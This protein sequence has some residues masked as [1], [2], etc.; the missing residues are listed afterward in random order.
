MRDQ[1]L[2]RGFYIQLFINYTIVPLCFLKGFIHCDFN[3]DNG[4]DYDFLTFFSSVKTSIILWLSKSICHKHLSFRANNFTTQM[5]SHTLKSLIR[6][7]PFARLYGIKILFFSRGISY[8]FQFIFSWWPSD[9]R[10]QG[11]ILRESRPVKGL[12]EWTSALVVM[13]A[14]RGRRSRP[15][16]CNDVA[17][18]RTTVRANQST[19]KVAR[20]FPIENHDLYLASP[21]QSCHR[22]LSVH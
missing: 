16:A 18:D 11:C 20:A 4:H 9:Y 14:A 13:M 15:M 1:T 6:L 17:N 22:Y 7:W 5:G 19:F 8:S 12:K 2:E 21:A 10:L 3:L